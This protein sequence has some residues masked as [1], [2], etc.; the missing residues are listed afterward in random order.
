[1]VFNSPF[2]FAS[3]PGV[4]H[5]AGPAAL[6]AVETCRCLG[7]IPGIQ[8]PRLDAYSNGSWAH[9]RRPRGRDRFNS[10][11]ARF[12]LNASAAEQPYVK[13]FCQPA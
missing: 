1:V 8:S 12:W 4:D 9:C 5:Q 13:N 7:S 11:G 6:P 2:H 3:A 10:P